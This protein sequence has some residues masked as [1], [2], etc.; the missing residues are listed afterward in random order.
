M[1]GKILLFSIG[2]AVK[3]LL[4]SIGRAVKILLPNRYLQF[5]TDGI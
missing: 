1:S 2:R 3:F 5:R 4:F